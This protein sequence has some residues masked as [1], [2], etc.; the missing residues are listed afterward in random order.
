VDILTSTELAA[1]T[2]LA[3]Q[4]LAEYNNRQGLTPGNE[5]T[6]DMIQAA[7]MS[8]DLDALLSIIEKLARP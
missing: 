6:W 1:I 8:V 2:E 5:G 4:H 7:R 3:G